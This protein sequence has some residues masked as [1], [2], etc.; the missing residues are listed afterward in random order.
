MPT[1][2]GVDEVLVTAGRAGAS[3]VNDAIQRDWGGNSGYFADPDGYRR[4]V[5][6]N[7]SP[8]GDYVLP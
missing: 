2:E 7:P 5:A 3:E 4:E 1:R 8:I 6:Y